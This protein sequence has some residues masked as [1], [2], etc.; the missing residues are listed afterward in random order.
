[1]R[2]CYGETGSPYFG[3]LSCHFLPSWQ[4]PQCTV[5]N[6]TIFTL[7]KFYRIPCK[8]LKQPVVWKMV[9]PSAIV[10]KDFFFTFQIKFFGWEI[11]HPVQLLPESPN[12][13][14]CIIW[15]KI[16]KVKYN[17]KPDKKWIKH[18]TVQWCP[19]VI[20]RPPLIT[21]SNTN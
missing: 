21:F 10:P 5:I 15:L 16:I 11:A 3:H 20:S 1:M 9:V 2:F 19:L 17:T 18:M 7:V 8:F 13:Y 12:L 14:I 6:L 4:P